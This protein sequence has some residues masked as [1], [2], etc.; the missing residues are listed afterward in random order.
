LIEKTPCRSFFSVSETVV[1][2]LPPTTPL[3]KCLMRSL[4]VVGWA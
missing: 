1:S 3:R 4:L 2:D